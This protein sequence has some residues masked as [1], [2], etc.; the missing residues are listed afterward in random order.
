MRPEAKGPDG[1][2]AT[3]PHWATYS[4]GGF[5]R[6]PGSHEMPERQGRVGGLWRDLPASKDIQISAAAWTLGALPLRGA[7]QPHILASIEAWVTLTRS[8]EVSAAHA[9]PV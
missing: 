8:P 7:M 2:S 9:T 4:K 1:P 5:E 3:L 6:A